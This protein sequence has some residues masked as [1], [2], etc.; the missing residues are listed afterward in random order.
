MN[1]AS[2]CRRASRRPGFESPSGVRTNTIR[3]RLVR[4]RPIAARK[5]KTS[6]AMAPPPRAPVQPAPSP[7]G[8]RP[9]KGDKSQ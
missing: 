3:Q 5:P 7:R 6:A 4:I 2:G 8:R 9:G 1:S